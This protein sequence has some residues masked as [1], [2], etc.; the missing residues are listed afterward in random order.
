LYIISTMTS[1]LNEI[2]LRKIKKVMSQKGIK[3]NRLAEMIGV[4]PQNLNAYMKGRRNFGDKNLAR[5]AKAL[6]IP[7]ESLYTDTNLLS[8]A[9][10]GGIVR[11]GRMLPVISWEKAG[12][13]HEAM[14][15]V[16]A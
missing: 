3:Q 5:I 13:W 6:E 11:G 1:K 10:V 12:L 2:A 7:I 16:G 15:V 4:V 14:D 9:V 8:Q